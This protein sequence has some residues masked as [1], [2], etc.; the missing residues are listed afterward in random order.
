MSIS[1]PQD[2]S[3]K[4]PF[5][6]YDLLNDAPTKDFDWIVSWLPEGDSFRVYNPTLFETQIMPRYF[7]QTRYK[8]FQRQ[9]N[10]YN[11]VRQKSGANKGTFTIPFAFGLNRTHAFKNPIKSHLLCQ[12]DP[13]RI[14]TSLERIEICAAL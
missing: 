7:N 14:L 10:L 1:E 11:F 8:S 12:K 5:Q 3:S 13:I 6:L 2:A 9:L 4:F